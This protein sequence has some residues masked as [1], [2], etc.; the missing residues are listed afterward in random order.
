MVKKISKI[1]FLI[2]K[3]FDDIF[4]KI[5][6][7]SILIWFKDFFEE[8]S[9]KLITLKK[10]N[11]KLK[12]FTPNFLSNWLVEDFYKKEPE[13]IEW[14]E[15]FSKKNKKFIFWDIGANIGLYSIYAAQIHK[16]SEV[17][18]FEPS[19]NN[20]RILSR[21]VFINNLNKKIKIFQLPLNNK[22][23]LF[24]EFKENKFLE[25]S[26]HNTFHYNFDFEGKQIKT[27]NSYSILGCSI[28]YIL[29][30]NLLSIPDY[31][32]IDVDG[33]EH[34]IFKGIGNYLSNKKIKEIQVEIN[35]NFETQ[36]ETVVN[37]LKKNGFYIKEKKRNEEYMG[38]KNEKFSKTYNYFFHRNSQRT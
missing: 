20:L 2:L 23:I 28:K 13:T 19:F 32:K 7:K 21:N 38:Y 15:T 29:D 30:N 22:N 36:F 27:G 24:S 31:I 35:E 14:I 12:F 9:Y 17:V 8:N 6:Q 18:S 10:S 26:S 37:L 16:Y 3:F 5:T 25:G 11:K 33:I 1:I 34:M 4:L